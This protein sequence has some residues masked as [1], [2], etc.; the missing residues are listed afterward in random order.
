[1]PNDMVLGN[2]PLNEQ[3]PDAEQSGQ[4]STEPPAQAPAE[5]TASE[6]PTAEAAQPAGATPPPSFPPAALPEGTPGAAPDLPPYAPGPYT[7]P[8]PPGP[9]YPPAGPYT[10]RPQRPGNARIGWVIGGVVAL[11]LVVALACAAFAAALGLFVARTVSAPWQ[12]ATV[13]RMFAVTGAPTIVTH[14]VTGDAT[15]VTGSDGT[16]KVEVTKR[17]RDFLGQSARQDLNRIGVNF[18][19]S[20]NTVTVDVTYP[21]SLSL[22]RQLAADLLITVPAATNIDTRVVT[23]TVSATGT[24]GTLLAD[25]TTGN[26]EVRGVN[27]TGGQSR[28]NVITGQATFDGALA[29]GASLEIRLTTGSATLT[30]PADTP[31]RLDAAVT[32]GN[33]T[34]TG[35]SIP[36]TGGF[37]SRRASGSLGANPTGNVTVNVVT[38]DITLVAK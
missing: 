37:T 31:A 20:G 21:S 36:I 11:V 25:V 15:F 18:T 26:V 34:V 29:N 4:P 38:G 5:T 22:N 3:P 28:I 2:P 30:L 23:G 27:L 8:Y 10:P 16:V 6:T 7:A 13:S 24:S 17:A 33:I 14:N 35:W 9:P 1:M 32:T 19:Q 12:Q